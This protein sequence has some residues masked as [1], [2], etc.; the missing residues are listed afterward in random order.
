MSKQQK[1]TR[2]FSAVEA[3]LVII[4][5]IVIG[6]V[7]YL[8]AKHEH[9]KS[10]GKS[11]T[12]SQAAKST[13]TA[14]TLKT[15]CDSAAKLCF[16]YLST[17]KITTSTATDGTGTTSVVMNPTASMNVAYADYATNQGYPPSLDTSNPFATSAPNPD[18]VMSITSPFN[19]YTVSVNP[20]TNND[21]HYKIVGGYAMGTT[22]NIPF[23]FVTNTSTVSTENLVVGK[24]TQLQ[25]SG[26]SLT[27]S[28]RPNDIVILSIGPISADTY[29][30]A[31]ATAWFGSSDG[32]TALQLMQSFYSQ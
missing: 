14:P 20:P 23:Y 6:V 13:S 8:V 27:D 11:S 25:N 16:Q 18:T 29:T 32:K 4:I 3:F 26:F 1:N 24:V 19:F 22:D 15:Y 10:T 30:P 21:A 9:N 12:T 5:L 7:G 28:V 2:G 17:W 31:Q